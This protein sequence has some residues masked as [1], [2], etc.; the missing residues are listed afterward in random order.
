MRKTDVSLHN[1]CI[2]SIRR[3]TILEAIPE[4]KFTN[5]YPTPAH[6]VE[7]FSAKLD[8]T[9][10]NE[11]LCMCSTV[12]DAQN[13]SVL[14]TQRIITCIEGEQQEGNMSAAKG[15]DQGKLKDFR[16]PINKGKIIFKD[17]AEMPFI[18]E[19]GKASMV[20]IYGVKTLVQI[21]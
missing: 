21:L 15:S 4:F 18:Y 17:D 6:F 12:I 1:T 8:I 13:W 3:H 2:A 20:M 19:N 5:F 14:T 11:E 16:K 10:H 7:E 9:L